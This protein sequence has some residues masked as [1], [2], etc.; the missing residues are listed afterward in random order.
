[1]FPTALCSRRAEQQHFRAHGRNV[2]VP[3]ARLSSALERRRGEGRGQ[4]RAQGSCGIPSMY[5]GTEPVRREPVELDPRHGGVNTVQ[6]TSSMD[7][8]L[9]RLGASGGGSSDEGLSLATGDEFADDGG[10]GA[11]NY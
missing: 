7:F 3:T 5:E 8:I 4:A 1:M 9:R 6:Y 2:A 11:L 10:H